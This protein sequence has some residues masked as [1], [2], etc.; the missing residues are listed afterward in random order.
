VDVQL[1][2]HVLAPVA[3]AGQVVRLSAARADL[4]GLAATL[5]KV[6]T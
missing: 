2:A 5:V 4:V 1:L 6:G 3:L